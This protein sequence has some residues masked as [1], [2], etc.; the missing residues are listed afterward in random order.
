VVEGIMS[1]DI[2][3]R[4]NII[5][6]IKDICYGFISSIVNVAYINEEVA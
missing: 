4:S 3:L 6:A 2:Y 5:G 1:E